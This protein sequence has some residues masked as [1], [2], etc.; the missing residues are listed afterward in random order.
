MGTVL[1]LHSHRHL[2]FIFAVL[3]YVFVSP[4]ETQACFATSYKVA[5]DYLGTLTP[6]EKYTAVMF[7]LGDVPVKD[8]P[9]FI[10]TFAGHCHG[11]SREP[12]L[13]YFPKVIT[14]DN[15]LLMVDYTRYRWPHD[16]IQ[17]LHKAHPYNTA[18]LVVEY[19]DPL[20]GHFNS[21]G[22]R[23]EKSVI[24]HPG[25]RYV[26]PDDSGRVYS[27]LAAGRYNIDLQFK[28]HH[29]V[30]LVGARWFIWQTLRN[31]DRSPNY[32]EF[33]GMKNL[34]DVDEATGF[35]IEVQT[36]A[37]R[38]DY[39]EV[40]RF[41]K[42]A[43]TFVRNVVI[44]P[45]S[46]GYRYTTED[47][48]L[49]T[50][51]SNF[52]RIPDRQLSV[53]DANEIIFPLPNGL[54]GYMLTEGNSKSKVRKERLV[55]AS[56][57]DFVGFD[58]STASNDARIE[59]I[60]C[61]RCHF[62]AQ[63]GGSAALIDFVPH[64]RKKLSTMRQ[65]TPDY[66]KAVEFERLYLRPFQHQLIIDRALYSQAIG[67]ATGMSADEWAYRLTTIFEQYDA[68]AT[69]DEAAAQL[70]CE[71][72]FVTGPLVQKAIKDWATKTNQLDNVLGLFAEGE[73][74]PRVLY[75]EV[76]PVLYDTLKG[77]NYVKKT[78]ALSA[79]LIDDPASTNSQRFILQL[80]KHIQLSSGTVLRPTGDIPTANLPGNKF[81]LPRS[82]PNLLPG[83]RTTS[84]G[85]NIRPN[86]N[87]P[88]NANLKPP[89]TRP[90]SNSGSSS[91]VN[92]GDAGT[93]PDGAVDSGSRT[94][95]SE[96]RGW[97][98]N[99]STTTPAARPCPPAP[100]REVSHRSDS[101]E[102][103]QNI[104]ARRPT[105]PNVAGANRGSNIPLVNWGPE[106]K[107][108]SGSEQVELRRIFSSDEW[109]RDSAA[110]SAG[111]WDIR[112]ASTVTAAN[113]TEGRWILGL[114]SMI[115]AAACFWVM[116]KTN[117]EA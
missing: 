93:R 67:I 28:A 70:G 22:F 65:N 27:N 11:L 96:R 66:E 103:V 110:T 36:K 100:L 47:S 83:V 2:V 38:S 116:W 40:P 16:V 21:S 44:E 77:M 45:I 4:Q 25:G 78:A 105:L 6:Y 52:I 15:S 42:I 84:S 71:T 60:G 17:K 73:A 107:D 117:K 51:A 35:N 74:I 34:Q 89:T 106:A 75:H 13:A 20:G 49:A 92:T 59:P 57:P 24:N 113:P 10:L 43:Q 54:P 109:D 99:G 31:N 46:G 39:V 97:W 29:V 50:G 14:A 41:S 56:A 98:S 37:L 80:P 61:L 108:A 102:G 79:K 7:W 85:N 86:N 115:T 101:R 33:L 48:R 95:G 64:F 69:L 87:V 53:H 1:G 68:G 30:P 8:R 76:Y 3:G 55:Q 90:S 62:R 63:F 111:Q 32:N 114:G 12:S 88:V 112:P 81:V 19:Q 18:E 5:V 9:M 72:K 26:V 82:N 94:G 104:R 23:T 58:R 91:F